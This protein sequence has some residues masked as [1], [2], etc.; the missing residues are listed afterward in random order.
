MPEPRVSVVIPT[1]RMEEPLRACLE[2]LAR[3]TYRDFRVLVVDN[4]ASVDGELGESAERATSVPNSAP[5][6]VARF[7]CAKAG[8]YHARSAGVARVRSELIAFTDADCRPTPGWLQAAVAAWDAAAK[9][10]VVSGP[11]RL[12][13]ADEGPVS[14]Y[15]M[16]HSYLAAVA[17]VSD[18]CVTA[19]WLM[20][21]RIYDELGGFDASL[22]SGADVICA[23]R[24]GG[25]L[26]SRPGPRDDRRASDANLP[27]GPVEQTS[28]DARR[29][30]EP[31]PRAAAHRATSETCAQAWLDPLSQDAAG[32]RPRL[33]N[34]RGA[35]GGHL[36]PRSRRQFASRAAA[37]RSADPGLLD[38][39]EVVRRQERLV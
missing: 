32:S 29:R 19:N 4:D 26:R 11:I 3:Q 7:G 24:Q 17:N 25:R 10:G 20:S 36:R 35:A 18:A 30:L 6:E 15:E 16:R 14:Q 33:R 13:P 12:F 27:L 22:K 2:H 34:A 5:L 31:H 23:A 28:A 21:T 8:S 9:P 38:D 37:S 39:R 1:F